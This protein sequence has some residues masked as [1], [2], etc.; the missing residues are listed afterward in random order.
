[1]R[2]LGPL[3]V[4]ASVAC[5][6]CDPDTPATPAPELEPV[7]ARPALEDPVLSGDANHDGQVDVADPVYALRALIQGGPAPACEDALDQLSDGLLDMSDAFT[8]LY[9][10]FA[11]THAEL[12][13]SE[14]LDCE[15]P[16]PIAEAP[17]GRLGL[18]LGG[19]DRLTGAPGSVLSVEVPVWLTSPDLEP[20]GWSF[21]VGAEGCTVGGAEEAGTVIAD[22]RLDDEGHRDVGFVRTD[23]VDGG[24]VH[25]AV[26]SWVRDVSL[27][28]QAGAY[29]LLTLTVEA[30][31]P[32][33]G[34][35][36]CTLSLVEGLQGPGQPVALVV[37]A[38][39]RS[40]TPTVAGQTLQVC[41]E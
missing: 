15:D 39:G 33:S 22:T 40:Y 3:L 4:L 28:A 16:T 11:G 13:G 26:L 19:S 5:D 31:V 41:A 7:C 24:V 25:G 6:G 27:P 21:G 34:C 30:T 18:S 8:L 12:R 32:A 9:F 35:T 29:R 36:P 38:G 37:S 23:L 14:R 1:M 10:L 17:C 2:G 20:Q